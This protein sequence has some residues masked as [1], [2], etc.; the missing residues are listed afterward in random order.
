MSDTPNTPDDQ[1]AT[2]KT[3]PHLL[4]TSRQ[5]LAHMGAVKEICILLATI[6]F[7]SDEKYIAVAIVLVRG[8]ISYYERVSKISNPL[9]ETDDK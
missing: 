4:E 7:L 1:S 5:V 2:P 9:H 8:V 3:L 6:S